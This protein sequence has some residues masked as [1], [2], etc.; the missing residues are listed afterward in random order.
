M[1]AHVYLIVVSAHCF[2]DILLQ[3]DK[4][5]VD[6]P[7]MIQRTRGAGDASNGK[8]HAAPTL[9]FG[10]RELCTPCCLPCLKLFTELRLV[11]SILQAHWTD[12][13]PKPRALPAKVLFRPVAGFPN[14]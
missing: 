11:N 5:L 3:G 8:R 12:V 1:N 14:L 10:K 9:N 6:G 4:S 2:G 7:V 13:P